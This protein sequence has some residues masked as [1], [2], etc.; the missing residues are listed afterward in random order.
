MG[1]EARD[2]E[3]YNLLDSLAYYENMGLSKQANNVRMLLLGKLNGN[4]KKGNG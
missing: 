2:V 1:V 3:L 4:E